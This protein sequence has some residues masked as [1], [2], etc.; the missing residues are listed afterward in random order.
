[1]GFLY[2]III[3]MKSDI[4]GAFII[5]FWVAVLFLVISYTTV[6]VITPTVSKPPL[7]YASSLFLFPLF[8]VLGIILIADLTKR[9][10]R[11]FTPFFQFYKFAL[12]GVLNT[13][14][15]LAVLNALI[16]LSSIVAGW[17]FSAFK[18]LSFAIAVTNSYFWNKFWTF[19]HAG[20]KEKKQVRAG[21]F[22]KFFIVSIAGLVV[23]V[24]VASF[25]VNVLGPMGQIP[26]QLWANI[27]A[28]AA[29]VFSTVWN[30]VGYKF[31]VF[32]K[33]NS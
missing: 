20:S 10:G 22:S 1:M 7:Y 26:P 32:K 31:F 19:A 25:F 12:V 30:F 18:G 13:L 21:E 6:T 17:E 28:L 4:F 23:N 11:M 14:L 29:I 15:D 16:A 5:G 24:G 9:L 2:A 27:A 3:H 8:A 33:N